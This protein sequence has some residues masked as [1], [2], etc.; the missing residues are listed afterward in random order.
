MHDV[1]YVPMIHDGLCRLC[2]EVVPKGTKAVLF[3]VGR[4]ATLDSYLHVECVKEMKEF[5]DKEDNDGA[6]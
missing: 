5:L 1:R 2:H 3:K 4:R 6:A